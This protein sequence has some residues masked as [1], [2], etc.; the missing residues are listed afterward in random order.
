M[1]DSAN[2]VR[3]AY[4]KLNESYNPILI[5]HLGDS[6]G[7]FSEYNGMIL[8]MLYCLRH[9]IQFRL[10]S[11][12]ANFKYEKGWS[13]YFESFCIEEDS[14]WHHWINMRPIGSWSSI[15]KSKN[16]NLIKWKI[17]KSIFN[18]LAKVYKLTHHNVILTQ[19]IWNDIYSKEQR[20][21]SY[22][23]PELS[24]NGSITDACKVLVELTW[25]FR[26]DIRREIQTYIDKV[27]ISNPFIG[28]Q[29]RAG[30]KY[31]EYDL[32]PIERYIQ[33]FETVKNINS[34]FVLTDDYLII[35]KLRKNYLK[36]HWYTL[37]E[38]TENGYVH[39]AFKDYS[40]DSKRK[41]LLKF[42]ASVEIIHSSDICFAT[43][44][45]NPSLFFAFRNPE[46]TRFVDFNNN[47]FTFMLN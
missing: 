2:H 11:K 28:C 36:W 31:I 7:F 1:K 22:N 30:D 38:E 4:R 23:I 26:A 27:N 14:K 12:D 45:S 40:L 18:C 20:L 33:P 17:K 19:D 25:R 9:H 46:K 41:Q 6:A 16:I 29:I 13:D 21:S 42:F 44:T 5:F 10:Y 43:I 35:K 47:V 24:I 3:E 37:C 39:A 8:A 32:L 34:I 15:L